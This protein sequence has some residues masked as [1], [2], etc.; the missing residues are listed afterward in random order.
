MGLVACT[1]AACPPGS[2]DGEYLRALG[3]ASTFELAGRGPFRLLSGW[4]PPFRT[5][6]RAGESRRWPSDAG[7]PHS[8]NPV[9]IPS[10][11]LT[12]DEAW[13]H[14]CEWTDTDS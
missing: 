12:R 4:R 8:P 13:A 1:L 10:M 11:P 7:S 9:M 6:V 5:N 2:L 14:L 3:S